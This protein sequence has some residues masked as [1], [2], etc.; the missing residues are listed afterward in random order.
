MELPARNWAT[1][2]ATE[3]RHFRAASPPL[4]KVW[5][6][7]SGDV[8]KFHF[9]IFYLICVV[10]EIVSAFFCVCVFREPKMQSREYVSLVFFTGSVLLC[11]S[12]I[13]H[14]DVFDV[15]CCMS[16]TAPHLQFYVYYLVL[17]MHLEQ[18]I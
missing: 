17:L 8:I 5:A 11:H 14:L 4:G 2:R 10:S 12:V 18:Q 15:V 3:I 16:A 1:M 6:E 9:R 13:C 7:L